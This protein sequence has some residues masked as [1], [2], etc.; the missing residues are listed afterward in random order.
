ML[1][2]TLTKEGTS[3]SLVSEVT[4]SLLI[5]FQSQPESLHPKRKI[6]AA[7]LPVGDLREPN[8]LVPKKK[9]FATKN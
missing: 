3:F 8:Y 2:T 4:N 5:V 7:E 1:S 9:D 6:D